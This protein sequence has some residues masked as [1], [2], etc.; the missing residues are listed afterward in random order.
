[1]N[2]ITQW[3]QFFER[4]SCFYREMFMLPLWYKYPNHTTD[5][6]ESLAIFLEG[7][8]F[9]RQGR[10]PDYFP[11][12]V[13]ALFY[14][15]QQNDNNFVP[16]VINNMIWQKFSQSLNNQNL[17]PKNNPLYPSTEDPNNLQNINK[18]PSVIE[19]IINQNIV[20]NNLTLTSY[21]QNRIV[22]NNLN[23]VFN[24]LI[25]IRGIG[26]KV[27]SFFLRDLTDVMQINLTNIQHRKLLQPIDIWVERV[28]KILSNNQHLNRAKVADWLFKFSIENNVSPERVN[29]GIWFFCSIIIVSEYKLNQVLNKLNTAQDIANNYRNRLRNICNQC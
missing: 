10:R 11:A 28:V 20:R 12:A 6:W 4:L 21:L 29:M 7:Y 23:D 19:F 15:K 27:A 3:L 13:D 1:M 24:S 9:E 14:C 26:N 22:Q 2:H 18:R 17:N 5:I 8:A 25:S 16:T